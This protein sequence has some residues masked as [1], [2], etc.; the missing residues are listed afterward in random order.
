MVIESVFRDI[1]SFVEVAPV[2]VWT[3]AHVKAHYTICVLSHLINRTI[4]TTREIVSHEQLYMKLAGCQIDRIEVQNVHL[5]TH[6]MTRA[7]TEQKELL[8]RLELTRLLT[9]N[10]LQRV[11]AS[12]YP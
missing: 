8:T 5:S 12:V 7:N 2:Y 9:Q 11:K 1:K 4:N 3:E 10:I 6:N